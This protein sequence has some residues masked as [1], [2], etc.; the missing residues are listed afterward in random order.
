MLGM[1]MN[2]PFG[3]CKPSARVRGSLT[4]Q[5]WLTE[6]GVLAC[7]EPLDLERSVKLTWCR[8]F[9]PLC[10]FHKAVHLHQPRSKVLSPFSSCLLKC[11][12]YLL[13]KGLNILGPFD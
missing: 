8:G 9:D 7:E 4:M 11:L 13:K 5:R 1:P 10:L 6:G 2:A 3:R 12:V